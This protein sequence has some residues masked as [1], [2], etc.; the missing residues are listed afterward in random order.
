MVPK[1]GYSPSPAIPSPA[2]GPMMPASTSPP[3]PESPPPPPLFGT[4]PSPPSYPPPPAVTVPRTACVPSAIGAGVIALP[5]EGFATFRLE[6]TS[7]ASLST[8]LHGPTS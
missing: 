3:E 7:S 6:V 5:S 4:P 8:S 1:P 2:P